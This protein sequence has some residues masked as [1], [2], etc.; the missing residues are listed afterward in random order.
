MHAFALSL[1]LFCWHFFLHFLTLVLSLSVSLAVSFYVWF[2]IQLLNFMC[3]LKNITLSALFC[4]HHLKRLVRAISINFLVV[5]EKIYSSRIVTEWYMANEMLANMRK[6]K[7][8]E[9]KMKFNVL[10]RTK[11]NAIECEKSSKIIVNWINSSF[12]TRIKETNILLT[13]EYKMEYNWEIE[14]VRSYSFYLKDRK[15]FRILKMCICMFCSLCALWV[16]SLPFH[17]GHWQIS[18][19]GVSI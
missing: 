10:W 7:N 15:M 4:K 2:S 16:S 5:Y 6:Q 12:L 1:P 13:S 14:I 8:N 11:K 9:H 3:V 18:L 19:F 17:S